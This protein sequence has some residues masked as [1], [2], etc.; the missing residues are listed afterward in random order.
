MYLCM[1]WDTHTCPV[2]A[3]GHVYTCA[4]SGTQMHPCVLWDTYVPVR[5]LG[6]TRAHVCSRTRICLCTFWDTDA[7]CVLWDTHVPVHALGHVPC[8]L[9]DTYMPVHV[10]GHTRDLAHAC[11]GTHMY[12]CVLR[13]RHAHA[14]SGTRMYLCVIWGT[15]MYLSC[16]PWE[17]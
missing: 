8:V 4:R 5:A 9:G 10:V 15:R 6:H 1:P 14:C 3:L 7:P 11:S 2:C 12:P 17:E 13:H 16:S